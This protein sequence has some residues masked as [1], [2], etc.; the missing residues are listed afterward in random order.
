MRYLEVDNI[1]IP[2]TVSMGIEKKA[3]N[4]L[5]NITDGQS[6]P[7]LSSV[8]EVG[9]VVFTWR[10]E[11]CLWSGWTA[12]LSRLPGNSEVHLRSLTHI[13]AHGLACKITL[14]YINSWLFH[15]WR[16]IP[17]FLGAVSIPCI[18]HLVQSSLLMNNLARTE[19][20]SSGEIDEVNFRRWQV[21]SLFRVLWIR[22]K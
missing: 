17:T 20:H 18:A 6:K 5:G 16:K 4:L 15:L 1:C 7:V 19:L 2:P 22:W 9:F 3:K 13:L 11:G 10:Q 8:Q 14:M 21:G 12:H